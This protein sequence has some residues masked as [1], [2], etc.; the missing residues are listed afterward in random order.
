MNTDFTS[1]SYLPQDILDIHT[2]TTASG[3][4]YN[5]LYEMVQA[6]SDRKLPLFGSSDHGP[7]MPGSCSEM[8]FCNFKVIP[9]ELFGIQLI[10]GCELNIMDYSGRVDLPERLLK[11][12]DYGIASIHDI[13]YSIGTREQN[14]AATVLAMKNPYVQIIGHPDNALI[15]LDYETVV[16][17]AKEQHVLLEVNNSSLKPDSPRP[18]ARE[19]YEIMLKLCRQY[20]VPVLVNSD[21]HCACDVGN[22]R[23]ALAML[24]ELEFPQELIVNRSLKALGEYLPCLS[25]A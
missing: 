2:H 13:C 11:R 6:A 17:E 5:T 1:E 22:H 7:A 4:A 20:N 9:R 3:H 12:L 14:T 25:K 19:N 10:M 16:R 23:Y 15:P 24:E 8:Y 21:A 18:G